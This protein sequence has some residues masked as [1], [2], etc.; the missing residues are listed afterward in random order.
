MRHLFKSVV[1][2]AAILG[3][4]TGASAQTVKLDSITTFPGD[5]DNPN[6]VAQGPGGKLYAISAYTYDPSSTS[7]SIFRIDPVAHTRALVRILDVGQTGPSASRLVLAPDGQ[8]YA[9][10]LGDNGGGLIRFNPSNNSA[11]V[12]RQFPFGPDG[13]PGID[14]VYPSPLTL[15]RDGL[16]YGMMSLTT[17]WEPGSVFDFDPVTSTFLTLHL[18]QFDVDG[19]Y[20]SAPLVEGADGVFYGSNSGMTGGNA[21]KFD[22]HTMVVTVLHAFD[23]SVEG[24]GPGGFGRLPDGRIVGVTT[25]GTYDG[26]DP[27][28]T[29]GGVFAMDPDSGAVT[30]LHMFLL[31][32]GITPILPGNVTVSPGGNLYVLGQNFVVGNASVFRVNPGTGATQDIQDLPNIEVG[33][34]TVGR[35]GRLYGVADSTTLFALGIL[36]PLPVAAATGLSGGTTTL[37]ATLKS[38]G[39]PL[40]GR[41]IA[42]TLNGVQVGSAVTDA[43][44]VAT[45]SNASLAG[46]APGAYPDGVG[47]SFDGDS[48]F[49]AATGTGVLSVLTGATPGLMVGDGFVATSAMLR[50]DFKLVVQE[51]ANGI[52]KG[53][54]EL[55]ISDID[56]GHKKK[57]KRNDVFKSTSYSEVVFTLDSSSPPQFD[58]VSFAGMGTWNGQAGYRFVASALDYLSGGRHNET[59]A[60]TIYDPANNVVDTVN[61]TLK[62]GN[63]KSHRIHRD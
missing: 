27:N 58:T 48:K 25:F 44:G 7:L 21:F 38:L 18:F 28:S 13:G 23:I 62:G 2:F 16:L 9:S 6:E 49:P 59:F 42:F 35:E 37:S 31:S 20:P 55:R 51:N 24:D 11:A 32:D 41:Q 46:I 40:A 56:D 45:L 52:D 53:K 19:G 63:L 14:G 29:T 3:A 4:A 15:G 57:T 10:Y 30:V 8:F 1:L 47:A 33:A 26:V 39:V 22:T 61:G 60:I 50:Y 34:L 17:N 54:L 5:G 12:V 36:D 43:N